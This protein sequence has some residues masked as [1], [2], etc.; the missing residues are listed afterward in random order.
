MARYAVGDIHGCFLTFRNLLTEKLKISL[1]DRV[2]L[3]GD[4]IDRGP[5]SKEVIDFIADLQGKRYQVYSVRGNHEQ[6]LLD[7]FKSEKDFSIWLRNGAGFSLKSFG[8]SQSADFAYQSLLKIAQKY[9]D[10]IKAL[11]YFIELEDYIIVHAGLNMEI[12]NPLKDTYA[13]LWSRETDYR[14]EKAGFKK[15]IHGHTPVHKETVHTLTDSSANKVFNIDTGCVY[16]QYSGFGYLTALDLDS[17]N[18]VHVKKME[19]K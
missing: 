1:S 2:Y 16:S 19:M 3:T 11:P 9:L 8:I 6:M 15:I 14:H 4:L 18:A 12:D 10:F 13:M 17:L 5:S 7:A